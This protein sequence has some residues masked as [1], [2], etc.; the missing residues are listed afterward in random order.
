MTA[1]LLDFRPGDELI[2]P[3]F[4]FVSCVTAFSVRGAR[5]MFADIGADTLNL[6]ETHLE[7]LLTPRTKAILPVH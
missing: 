2:V 3:S 6:D 4:T 1:Y 7:R 5:P